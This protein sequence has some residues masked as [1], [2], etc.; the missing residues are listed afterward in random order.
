VR[1]AGA[2]EFLRQVLAPYFAG[3]EIDHVELDAMFHL[4]FAEIVEMRLPALILAQVIRDAFREED[5]SGIPQSITRCAMLI[6][7]PAT[8]IRSFTSCTTLTGPL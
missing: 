2:F 8:L 6:P 4:A 3:V 7:A 1:L 5:V